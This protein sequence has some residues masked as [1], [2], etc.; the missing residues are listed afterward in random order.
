MLFRST[1][2]QLLLMLD[3]DLYEPD[4]FEQMTLT[5]SVHWRHKLTDSEDMRRHRGNRI[6][7]RKRKEV[8]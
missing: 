2:E 7:V 4:A 6:G 5:Q 8:K 3:A 1:A